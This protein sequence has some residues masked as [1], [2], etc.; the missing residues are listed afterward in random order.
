MKRRIFTFGCSFTE[1]TWP[2]W[3]DQILYK[4]EGVN[5]GICGGGYENIMNCLVQCDFD[6]KLTPDDVV[7]VVYPNLLR[8]DCAIYPKTKGFGNAITSPWIDHK[9]DLWNIEGMVYKNL[10]IMVMVDTF[11]KSKGVIYRYSSITK[12]FTYLEN[13]FNDDY[14]VNGDVLEHLNTVKNSLPFLQDFYTYLYDDHDTDNRWD[15]TKNWSNGR[16]EYHP[17]PEG[18]YRWLMNVLMPTL[19]ASININEYDIKEIEDYLD[20]NDDFNAVEDYFSKSE[21]EQNRKDWYKL[22]KKN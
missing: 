20:D 21:Y 7:V 18:H 9:D 1:Y 8:W 15:C 6:Y 12:I 2:T 10:N 13:Y 14:Q 22:H 4:N 3:A 19:D 5:Y 16:G 11:L 17:R